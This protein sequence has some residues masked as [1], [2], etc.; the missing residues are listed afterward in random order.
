M[1]ILPN[2]YQLSITLYEGKLHGKSHMRNKLYEHAPSISIE[3]YAT[4]LKGWSEQT[5]DMADTA[6][7]SVE[8]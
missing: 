2:I 4:V 1:L 5:A 7:V 6:I 8:R 3:I